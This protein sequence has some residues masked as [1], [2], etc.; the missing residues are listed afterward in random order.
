MV[1]YTRGLH[2]VA[3]DVWAWLLPDGGWGWSN[4]GL[5]RGKGESFLID[6]L[7]DLELTGEML[8]AMASVTEEHP[9]RAALNTH[10]N[11]DHCFGNQLLGPEVTIHATADTEHEMRHGTTPERL[12]GLVAGDHEP[13]LSE[14]FRH[15]F[16]AFAFDG[17]ILRGPDT[18]F[19]EV[20]TVDVGGR[21]VELRRL[22]PA[23]THGDAVAFVPDRGVLFTGDLLFNGGTPIMWADSISSWITA[24]DRMIE[25][26][27]EVVVPG[28]GAVTDVDGIV[29]M[30]DYLAVVRDGV[31]ASLAAG[32]SWREAVEHLDLGPYA[33]WPQAER[34]VVTVYNAYRGARLETPVSQA[35]ELFAEMARWRQRHQG[36]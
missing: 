11:G 22:G 33:C 28:H 9:I 35:T 23:H 25:L 8:G 31:D 32:R 21:P 18:T 20:R 4:A 7:F 3:E 2:R 12:A 27:P 14:F 30:R 5:V 15:C 36:K 19:D 24:C 1:E 10:A 13:L 26:G 17:I 6:T 29:T 34:V 16:G